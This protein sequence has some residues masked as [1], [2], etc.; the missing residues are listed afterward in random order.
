MDLDPSLK[1]FLKT[2]ILFGNFSN[3]KVFRKKNNNSLESLTPKI[4]IHWH[5]PR[6]N[7]WTSTLPW[8]TFW[9]LKYFSEIFQIEKCSEKKIIILWSPHPQKITIHWHTPRANRWTS[10]LPWKTFWKLK[11][12]LEISQIEKCSENSLESPHP[13]KI[14]IHWHTPRANGGRSNPLW[15][16][17]NRKVFRKFFGVP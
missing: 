15:N 1:N 2:Q 12:F 17:S 5:A 10:I 16:L 4:T 14:T 7:R 8:K 13:Q 6:A 9:K 11:Y 3:W